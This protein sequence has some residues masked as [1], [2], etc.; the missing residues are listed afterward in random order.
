MLDFLKARN[1][2]LWLGKEDGVV[3]FYYFFFFVLK[4]VAAER[5]GKGV[6]N[7]SHTFGEDESDC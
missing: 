5:K 7:W 2:T 1:L 6:E 4:E 3:F